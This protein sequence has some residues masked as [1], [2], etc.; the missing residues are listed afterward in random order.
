MSKEPAE[1]AAAPPE[2]DLRRQAESSAGPPSV[3][4]VWLVL[5]AVLGAGMAVGALFCWA[6]LRAVSQGHDDE[7]D[8]VAGCPRPP[9]LARTRASIA[10]PNGRAEEVS[11]S[12]RL[13][14]MAID[15]AEADE[16]RPK[17]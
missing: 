8:L 1:A 13:K 10:P 16:F 14:Q 2:R 5:A 12:S 11:P 4:G 15:D 3:G 6:G 17:N 9:P 7:E